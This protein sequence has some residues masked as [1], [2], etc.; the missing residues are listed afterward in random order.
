MDKRTFVKQL[1]MV[2]MMAASDVTR[3]RYRSVGRSEFVDVEF[4]DGSHKPVNVTAD[5]YLALALDVMR[6]LM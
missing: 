4:I 6:A 5:S 2:V 1:S 3:L